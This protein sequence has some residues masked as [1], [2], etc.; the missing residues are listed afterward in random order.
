[1]S[2]L[3]SVYRKVTGKE[4]AT[5]LDLLAWVITG[6]FPGQAGHYVLSLLA[7]PTGN[8]INCLHRAP[9]T[10][11]GSHFDIAHYMLLSVI[12]ENRL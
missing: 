4:K 10:V 6:R 1:M 2:P 3:T 11:G 7:A 9:C 5:T 12:F 8:T